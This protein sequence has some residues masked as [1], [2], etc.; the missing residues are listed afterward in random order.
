MKSTDAQPVAG[1][2]SL[3]HVYVVVTL[4]VIS[5][6]FALHPQGEKFLGAQN[7]SNLSIELAITATLALGM[8]LVLLPGLIDLSVG[9]GVGMLGGISCVLIIQH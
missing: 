2:I 8:F 1:S 4:L 6:F 7:L 5:L 9:S 3:R